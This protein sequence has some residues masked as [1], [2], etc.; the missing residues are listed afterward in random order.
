MMR[1]VQADTP[2]MRFL[3]KYERARIVLG[4]ICL[5]DV[6]I[7]DLMLQAIPYL[8]GGIV[9]VVETLELIDLVHQLLVLASPSFVSCGLRPFD[10]LMCPVLMGVA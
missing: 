6:G 4:L 3:L 5:I 10:C 9:M 8:L 7:V 2:L 1:G